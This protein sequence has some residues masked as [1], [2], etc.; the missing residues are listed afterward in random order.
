MQS[1]LNLGCGFKTSGNPAVINI[2]W[3]LYLRLA[4]LP[5]PRSVISR[6]LGPVRAKNLASVDGNILLHDLRRGIPFP[7]CSAD[8]VY[9]SHFLEHI[10][11]SCVDGLFDDIFRV[12]KPAGIHRI[13]CPDLTRI[14]RD[15]LASFDQCCFDGISCDGHEFHV[16]ELLEQSIRFESHGT[17]K[18]PKFRR[19]L[20]N[21]LLGDARRR[22]ELHLWMYDR[23]LLEQL[24]RRSG[25]VQISF[26]SFNSSNIKS[27]PEFR[28]ETNAQGSEY[29][30]GSLYCEATKPR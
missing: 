7:D 6:C 4:K 13:V 28:L 23:V 24:L 29:L 19:F 8:A 10:P 16:A 1:L 17:S 5:L 26:P 30:P 3:S 12:L 9:H 20:E 18:Q 25:F 14:V 21:L 27:F 22:G 15:Y 2:D 11:R